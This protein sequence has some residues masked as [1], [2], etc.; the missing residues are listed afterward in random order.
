MI[1]LYNQVPTVYTNVSRDFQYIS[2]LFNIVLN[3]VKHNVDSLYDLPICANDAKLTELLAMTLGF[4]IKRNYDISQLTALVAI[5]PTVLRYK[6]TEKSILMAARALVKATGSLG[7]AAVKID[8]TEVRV[9]LPKDLSDITLFLD[10]LDY[11]LPAGMTCRVVRK[12]EQSEAIGAVEIK[13]HDNIK[14]LVVDDFAIPQLTANDSSTVTAQA[15]LSSLYDF[16][17]QH[18]P[19]DFTSNIINDETVNAGLLDNMVIPVLAN[20]K[21]IENS[22]ISDTDALHSTDGTDEEGHVAKSSKVYNNTQ[23]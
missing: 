19:Y 15:D 12:N 10:L 23:T 16:T 21:I 1:N 17:S 8:G 14:L 6:G 3:S 7:E 9:T 11:I 5:L 2:W 18:R 13:Q 4:K 20:S 22:Y